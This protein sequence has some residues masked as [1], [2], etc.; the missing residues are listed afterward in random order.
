MANR[1]KVYYVLISLFALC[2]LICLGLYYCIDVI[3][4]VTE[5]NSI[6]I[7]FNHSRPQ[8]IGTNI[9][10]HYANNRLFAAEHALSRVTSRSRVM[11]SVSTTEMPSTYDV[12]L[13]NV[14][15]SLFHIKI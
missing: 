12:S 8:P 13:E 10:T 7:Q 6:Q 4:V 15:G 3:A 9:C 5:I 14:D 11:S 1:T 2:I